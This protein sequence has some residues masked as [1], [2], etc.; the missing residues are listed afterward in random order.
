MS[1]DLPLHPS[2]LGNLFLSLTPIP[3]CCVKLFYSRVRSIDVTTRKSSHSGNIIQTTNCYETILELRIWFC[4]YLLGF[5][6]LF[7]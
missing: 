4:K 5:N 7:F 2:L 3:N 6:S 1:F